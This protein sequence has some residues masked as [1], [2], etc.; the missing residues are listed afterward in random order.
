MT[1]RKS[2][3]TAG[4]DLK[5]KFPAPGAAAFLKPRLRRVLS[6]ADG[7]GP[8]KIL[9]RSSNKVRIMTAYRPLKVKFSD[10]ALHV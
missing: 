5:K 7:Q 10:F 9:V 8:A 4:R 1:R 3:R 2:Q 6:D